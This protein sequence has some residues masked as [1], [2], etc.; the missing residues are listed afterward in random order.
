VRTEQRAEGSESEEV[1]RPS[2]EH[3]R[4]SGERQESGEDEGVQPADRGREEPTAGGQQ[5]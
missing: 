1:G 4:V 3:D 2:G 5:K